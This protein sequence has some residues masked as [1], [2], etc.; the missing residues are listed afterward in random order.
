MGL[1][2]AMET[3]KS[4]PLAEVRQIINH[5]I[6]LQICLCSL[7]NERTTATKELMVLDG[8]NVFPFTAF[9]GLC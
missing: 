4:Q 9:R 2:I 3:F 1:F 7:K 5:K 8:Q 6:D